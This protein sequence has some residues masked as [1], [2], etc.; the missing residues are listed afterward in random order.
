[1]HNAAEFSAAFPGPQ[2]ILGLRLLPLSLGRYR[3]L[4]RFECPFVDDEKKEINIEELNKEL[5]FSLVICALPCDEFCHLLNTGK[6]RRE[7]KRWG[8][9]LTKIVNKKGFSILES[10]NAF[11]KYLDDGSA[12]PWVVLSKQDNSETSMAHWSSSIDVVLRSKVGW[13]E[14]EINESPMTK[15]LQDFFKYMESEGMVK[16]Y[17]HDS[18]RGVQGE[19]KANGDALEKILQEM[20]HGS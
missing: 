20:N 8:K 6:L 1:M 13:T 15:A 9:K 2:V 14:K 4:K 18:Y 3:L 16:L 10:F 7:L 19:A 17:D 5:F 11:R 12:V